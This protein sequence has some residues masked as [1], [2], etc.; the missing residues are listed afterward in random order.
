MK[1]RRLLWFTWSVFIVA[2][3]VRVVKDGVALPEGVPG[4]QALRVALD[5]V[6]P[7]EGVE[8]ATWWAAVL[9]VLS[10]STNLL[11]IASPL[12]G[13]MSH[14]R[15]VRSLR[16]IALAAF[17]VNA[18]WWWY[19][20]AADLRLGYLLWWASFL[21]LGIAGVMAGRVRQE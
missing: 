1:Q 20:E 11:M 10:A 2:W 7:Y 17:V 16:L 6:W 19:F 3:F 21:F 8:Y 14:T 12:A 5:P 9:A 13:V 4:W 15:D 18:Q